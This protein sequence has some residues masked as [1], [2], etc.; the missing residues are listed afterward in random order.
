MAPPEPLRSSPSRG[1]GRAFGSPSLHARYKVWLL[2]DTT[3]APPAGIRPPDRTDIHVAAAFACSTRTP[4]LVDRCPFPYP[5]RMKLLVVDDDRMFA[6][7]V[8]RGM[9]EEGHTVDVAR[10][11]AEGR[12][13]ALV[14]DYDGVILDV[15]L[16][17]GNGIQ[18]AREIRSSGRTRPI[19][20]L[21]G[22]DS[23]EDVVRG[24]DNGADD[25]LTK[26]FEMTE[27]KARMRAL[28][29]RGGGRR[30]EALSYGG[31]ELDRMARRATA[32]GQ[33]LDL[34]PKESNL[35]EYLLLHPEEVV[36]RTE[37]L[38]KVWDLHFDP[39]SN[40]VDVH[41]ARLRGKLR[42]AACAAQLVTMRGVGFMLSAQPESAR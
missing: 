18:L 2:S 33:R 8:R 11:L 32:G 1:N 19:L 30:A 28:L 29:R 10:T 5:S 14:N 9:T 27:L 3:L 39:G 16:P 22:N 40:V 41:V 26:P 35:L 4:V 15:M 23:T 37:L 21:T 34:T 12:V 42:K 17:D 36:T 7:L 25:Y 20:R 24:L 38:E 31:V 13:T 6:E